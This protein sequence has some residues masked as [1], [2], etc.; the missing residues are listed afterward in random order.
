[1]G[2]PNVAVDVCNLMLLEMKEKQIS[3]ISPP[4]NGST[5]AL[6]CSLAYENTRRQVLRDH[7]WN[8]ASNRK[9]ISAEAA[10]PAFGWAYAY[11][12][13]NDF[14]RLN[15]LGQDTDNPW[16]SNMYEFENNQV[17]TDEA[18]PLYM[19]YVSNFEDV[20]KMPA[21]FIHAFAL[22]LGANTCY[23]ITGNR[24]LANDFLAKYDKYMISVRAV[25]GQERPPTRVQKSA[26]LTARS[27]RSPKNDWRKW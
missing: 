15:G 1:M 18:A 20:S 11:K 10:A 22:K 13:P 25:D 19:R 7:P 24:A 9:T 23:G 6:K 12:V 16:P 2:Q 21:D 27:R 17:L 5:T 8:F 4:D 26:L 3:S 14:V